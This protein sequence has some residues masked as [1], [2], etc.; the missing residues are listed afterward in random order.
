M[1]PYKEIIVNVTMLTKLLNGVLI[2]AHNGRT[3]T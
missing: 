1:L 2:Q 3:E